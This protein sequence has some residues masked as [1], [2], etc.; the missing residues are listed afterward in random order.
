[1][2][3][4]THQVRLR[5]KVPMAAGFAMIKS[6]R[7]A[8]LRAGTVSASSVA[9]PRSS[10]LGAGARPRLGGNRRGKGSRFR[11]AS[12]IADRARRAAVL[13][14]IADEAVHGIEIRAV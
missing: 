12:R 6:Q 2:Q 10:S 5:S 7:C 1:M 9:V 4:N 8:D 14:E 11:C 3:P 13:G